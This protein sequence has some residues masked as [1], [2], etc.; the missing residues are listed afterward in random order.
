VIP[1]AVP[2]LDGNEARYLEEC[3]TSTFVS[4]VGPFVDTFEFLVAKASGS[5]RAVATQSG[6]AGLHLALTAMGVGRDDLVILP[7]FTFIASANAISH[8]GATPWLFDVTPESWNLGPTSLAG[9]LEKETRREK[10]SLIHVPTGRRVAAVMPVHTLGL[11]ADMDRIVEIAR[12]YGLP[13]ITDAAAALGATD[14]GRPVGHLGADLNVFSFNG[15]KTVTAGGGGAVTGDDAAL[16]D[17]V[18]HLSTT[19]RSGADYHHDH[20]GF[21]Y[22]MTNLQ[23]AVGCAQMERIDELVDAKRRIRRRYDQHLGDLSGVGIFPEVPGVES[24]C[25]LSGIIINAE[26]QTTVSELRDKLRAAEI[27]TRP[28]WKPVHMQPPYADAPF[29]NMDVSESLWPNVLTLPCS[30]GLNE[31]DQDS[32]IAAVRKA[33][34]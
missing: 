14:K 5:L 26:L 12:S 13:V 33:L 3:V 28:F 31:S 30:T 20:I 27:D 11:P 29:A 21:N 22:R 2:N 23:A 16:M 4:T 9:R 7:S 10:E 15:N 8:C 19:A 24:A 17:F 25:W 34:S 18:R 1:L 32:V 6:T